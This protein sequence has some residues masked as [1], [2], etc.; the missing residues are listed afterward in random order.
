M[1]K[2]I[3][4]SKILI[5]AQY[6]IILVLKYKFRK[7]KETRYQ[8]LCVTI[9]LIILEQIMYIEDFRYQDIKL[10]MPLSVQFDLTNKCNLNCRYCYNSSGKSLD[11]EMTIDEWEMVC[12]DI[13]DQGGVFQCTISGGEPLLVKDKLFYVLNSLSQDNTTFILNTN[14]TLVT[15][16]IVVEFLKYRWHWIQV[17]LDSHSEREHDLIRGKE[18]SWSDAINGIK[19]IVNY[20]IPV[21]I[22]CMVTDN[23]QKIEEII[24]L[25]I[26]IKAKGI[27]FSEVFLSGRATSKDI[28]DKATHVKL[29]D[30]INKLKKKYNKYIDINLGKSSEEEIYDYLN[31]Q[32]TG[33]VIKANG[34]V[35]LNCV[36]PYVIG[37]VLRESIKDIWLRVYDRDLII[38]E[39]QRFI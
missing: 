38:E 37:N 27:I 5:I 19:K 34:D 16:E 32:P 36:F 3:V 23:N 7:F 22:A 31:E 21:V 8:E 24:R 1:I 33:V 2:Y 26:K 6:K 25:A 4:V 20:G 10:S 17:S 28:I 11:Y 39:I 13:L 30:T 9:P 14:A 15:D 35:K 29:L 12:L 18:S